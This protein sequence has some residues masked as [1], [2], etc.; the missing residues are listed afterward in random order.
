M[1]HGAL[2]MGHWAWGGVGG[3]GRN[4]SP[5]TPHTPHTSHTPLSSHTPHTPHTSHTPL[6]SHTPHT[7]P[8]PHALF[9]SVHKRFNCM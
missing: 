3:W 2:G 5:H 4:L 9:P 7:P 8:S 1:G 6:S